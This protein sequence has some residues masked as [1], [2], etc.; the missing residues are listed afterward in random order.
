MMAVF[1]Q[2]PVS[3]SVELTTMQILLFFIISIIA[4]ALSIGLFI[5]I[6]YLLKRGQAS[7]PISGQPSLP[8]AGVPGKWGEQLNAVVSRVEELEKNVSAVNERIGSLEAR[9]NALE[10]KT[11]RM[12]KQF[13]TMVNRIA[14]LEKSFQSLESRLNY[15]LRSG[16]A[17]AVQQPVFKP[18]V[19]AKPKISKLTSINDLKLYIPQLQYA[20]LI[21]SQGYI[22][23]KYGQPGDDPPKLLEVIKISEK[24][25]NS[26]EVTIQRGENRI[27]MF[28]LGKSEDLDIYGIIAVGKDT[29]PEVVEAAK[30]ALISYF[31][32]KYGMSP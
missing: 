4:L 18:T 28:H 24:F 11:G 15:V 3:A 8:Q 9:L 20:V 25:T 16:K 12:E 2:I 31:A 17:A 29:P 10:A 30:E 21:T 7:M 23:E 32:S 14:S 27:T 1:T 6:L 13:S 26:R 5:A 22:V 19:A